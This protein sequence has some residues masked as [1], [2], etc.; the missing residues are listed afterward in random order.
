M[1]TAPDDTLELDDTLVV[2]DPVAG[3]GDG[4]AHDPVDN[5]AEGEDVPTFGDE[6]DDQPTDLVK[7]LRQ[8]LRSRDKELAAVRKGP[9]AEQPI[10]VGTEPDIEDFEFDSE[11]FRAAHREW[12]QRGKDKD[13]QDQRAE[14][15]Q[16]QQNEAWQQVQTNYANKRAALKFA[17]KDQVESAAFEALSP[18]QQAVIAKVA[19][20][21]ALLIYAVGKNPAKLE[22][23]AAIDDPLVLAATIG[24]MGAT[25]QMK[26]RTQAPEPEQIVRGGTVKS[27]D[28][29]RDKLE[30]EASRT[31]D[32]SKLVGYDYNKEKK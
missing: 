32:Y 22:Q 13:A 25:L 10:E 2:D 1:A 28:K 16:R 6:P 7:H 23:L 30:A 9:Q 20:D 3:G 8:Q 15:G 4:E 21:P 12:M 11:R 19:S 18:T 29:A 24:R 14:Q 31:G 5:D 26:K 17:D 27:G